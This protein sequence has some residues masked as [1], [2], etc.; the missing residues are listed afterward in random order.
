MSA[1]RTYPADTS[2]RLAARDDAE[3][4]YFKT[5]VGSVMQVPALDA[6]QARQL[7]ADEYRGFG[8]E[9]FERVDGFGSEHYEDYPDPVESGRD[10]TEHDLWGLRAAT[11]KGSRV[12]LEDADDDVNFAFV[13]PQ[14]DNKN[15]LRG[16][17]EGF[18]NKPFACLEC[19]YSSLLPS[20]A[21]LEFKRSVDTGRGGE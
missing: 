1:D 20:E 21:I 18:A 13:C 6:E 15:P 17:P 11:R 8:P 3:A 7:A 2:I 19:E 4:Y 12:G 16:D 10:V 9:A 14:C 5:P